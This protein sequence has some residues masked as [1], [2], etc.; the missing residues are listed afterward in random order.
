MPGG[1]PPGIFFAKNLMGFYLKT[2]NVTMVYPFSFPLYFYEKNL[3]VVAD[4]FDCRFK[5]DFCG[6]KPLL[7][8]I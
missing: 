6:H 4:V 8:K 5:D 1:S 2:G 3:F 7:H